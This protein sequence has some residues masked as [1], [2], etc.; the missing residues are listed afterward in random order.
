MAAMEPHRADEED[1]ARIYDELNKSLVQRYN[2]PNAKASDIKPDRFSIIRDCIVA[3]DGKLM[4]GYHA[5]TIQRLGRSAAPGLRTSVMPCS[6][7]NTDQYVRI[8]FSVQEGT[9]CSRIAEV[10]LPIRT[11]VDV[12]VFNIMNPSSSENAEDGQTDGVADS[13]ETDEATNPTETDGVTD[14]TPENLGGDTSAENTS[15]PKALREDPSAVND[16]VTNGAPYVEGDASTEGNYADAVEESTGSSGQCRTPEPLDDEGQY[17]VGK[18]FALLAVADEAGQSSKCNTEVEIDP[19]TA[20]IA[21]LSGPEPAPTEEDTTVGESKAAPAWEDTTVGESESAPTWEDAPQAEATE[22]PEED[23]DLEEDENRLDPVADADKFLA[24][25]FPLKH[26][27]NKTGQWDTKPKGYGKQTQIAQDLYGAP[28]A[29]DVTMTQYMKCYEDGICEVTGT[30][31]GVP[32]IAWSRLTLEG[33]DHC[34]RSIREAFHHA[35]RQINAIK[36]GG[37]FRIN[38]PAGRNFRH[39]WSG[40]TDDGLDLEPFANVLRY[41][42]QSDIRDLDFN[43]APYDR[44]PDNFRPPPATSSFLTEQHRAVALVGGTVEE[45][46]HETKQVDDCSKHEFRFAMFPVAGSEDVPKDGE[47]KEDYIDRYGVE[48][49]GQAAK[50]ILV[51]EIG[52]M[53][54]SLPEVGQKVTLHL[55]LNYKTQDPPEVPMNQHQKVIMQED[56]L[57]CLAAAEASASN[58][59]ENER[60]RR[61]NESADEPNEEEMMI[62]KEEELQIFYGIYLMSY[63]APGPGKTAQERDTHRILEAQKIGSTLSRK[64]GELGQD[65]GN[66][67]SD[68]IN[69]NG[70]AVREPKTEEHEWVGHRLPQPAGVTADIFVLLLKAPRQ[71]NWPPSLHK[72]LLGFEV[73]RVA[74][75]TVSEE[76]GLAKLTTAMLAGGRITGNMFREVDEKTFRQRCKAVKMFNT[77][78]LGGLRRSWYKYTTGFD[79]EVQSYDL[80]EHCPYIVQDLSNGVFSRQG[81]ATVRKLRK[82]PGGIAIVAGVP[83]SG[84]TTWGGQIAYGVARSRRDAASAATAT[85]DPVDERETEKEEEEV[86]QEEIGSRNMMASLLAKTMNAPRRAAST[87]KGKKQPI[88][89]VDLSSEPSIAERVM[90]SPAPHGPVL[91]SLAQNQQNKDAAKRFGEKYTDMNVGLVFP[92]KK[93]LRTLL[94]PAEEMTGLFDITHKSNADDAVNK[95]CNEAM[96]ERYKTLNPAY[97]Q[98]SLSSITRDIVM[99]SDDDNSRAIRSAWDLAESSPN[100]FEKNS[101][102]FTKCC[103]EKL[104][105]TFLKLDFAVATPVALADWKGR[106]PKTWEPPLVVLDEAARMH[107]SLALI[108]LSL[109]TESPVIMLGDPHQPGPVE[110]ISNDPDFPARHCRQNGMSLM[111]RADNCGAL[112]L[113]L[114]TN[115]RTHGNSADHAAE[116]IYRGAM[117]IRNRDS[118]EARIHQKWV[119]QHINTMSM[120]VWFDLKRSMETQSGTSYYNAP[121]ARFTTELVVRAVR[122]NDFKTV[123]VITPYKQQLFLIKALLRS[124]PVHELPPGRVDVRTIDDAPSAEADCVIVDYV[125]T[126]KIGFLEDIKRQAVAETRAKF[127]TFIVGNDKID[128]LDSTLIGKW[129]AYLAALDAV[130]TAPSFATWCSKCYDAGHENSECK[131]KLKCGIC[132]GQHA[133]RDCLKADGKF[134]SKDLDNNERVHP[135]KPVPEES[136]NDAGGKN[137]RRKSNQPL[138]GKQAKIREKAAPKTPSVR[139]K[140]ENVMKY[141]SVTPKIAPDMAGEQTTDAGPAPVESDDATVDATAGTTVNA[142]VGTAEVSCDASRPADDW[143]AT[144]REDETVFEAAEA[145]RDSWTDLIKPSEEVRRAEEN[146]TWW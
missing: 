84:K 126:T 132:H 5:D 28:N 57:R 22:N 117:S 25:R 106:L 98:R 128:R 68:W 131:A 15:A 135:M 56:I 69:D 41:C 58:A 80:L 125:R 109:F 19:V 6:G 92:F 129:R 9:S 38:M 32:K 3:F 42:R 97:D 103:T 90:L 118:M 70:F 127:I 60:N 33:L 66:R 76:G 39:E 16:C 78:G 13:T 12:K 141:G 120:A 54:A 71:T 63:M 72:P 50:W 64:P 87:A 53:R 85:S 11:G 51:S 143:P 123:M 67:V 142:T 21:A 139:K 36:P 130:V 1:A 111:E 114:T 113:R 37:K 105:E 110:K 30:F 144:P 96:A 17:V 20:V 73:E 23:A 34:T 4:E 52:G 45:F 2:L 75:P 47:S 94:K 55:D 99:K 93:E 102:H 146:S 77:M 40:L 46:H 82:M 43:T 35:I 116:S 65:H 14:L 104:V 44:P 62:F 81:A 140:V 18:S 100:D 145:H 138:K 31:D 10:K 134:F 74:V 88:H 83:G 29:K 108:P 119:K 112:T 8:V 107:E 61:R 48:P 86:A 115:Y 137:L 121:S 26:P 24:E 27:W 122:E 95:Y 59:T 49:S 89:K 79:R 91:W 101:G 136:S 7:P 133:G 124:I